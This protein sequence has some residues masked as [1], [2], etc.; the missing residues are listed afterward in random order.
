MLYCG[1]DNP[2]NWKSSVLKQKLHRKISW[3]NDEISYVIIWLASSKKMDLWKQFRQTY[4]SKFALNTTKKLRNVFWKKELQK[5]KVHRDILQG[6]SVS[7]FDEIKKISRGSRC[8]P[9]YSI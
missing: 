1:A 2:E 8:N 9:T 5:Q 6:G 3:Q 4:N 7:A